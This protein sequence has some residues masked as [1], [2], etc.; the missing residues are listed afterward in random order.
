MRHSMLE[1][2]VQGITTELNGS[3]L[4]IRAGDFKIV[5]NKPPGGRW[6]FDEDNCTVPFIVAHLDLRKQVH[7]ALNPM[8]KTSL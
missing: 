6:H 5:A 3:N 1:K 2:K 7:F 8:R 4:I